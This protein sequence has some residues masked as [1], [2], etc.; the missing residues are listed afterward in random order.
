M[1]KKSQIL[2][3]FIES[4]IVLSYEILYNGIL[5]RIL[6]HIGLI[7]HAASCSSKFLDVILLA[8]GKPV[9]FILRYRGP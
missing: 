7:H 8:A 2:E 9:N 3:Q 4:R 1:M 6:E 5:M